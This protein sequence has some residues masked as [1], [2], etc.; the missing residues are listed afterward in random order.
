MFIKGKQRKQEGKGAV[1]SQYYARG[2]RRLEPNPSGRHTVS[3]AHRTVCHIHQQEENPAG[4]KGGR[5]HRSGGLT[6]VS[7]TNVSL[8][9][10]HSHIYV[11]NIISLY[12]Y[13]L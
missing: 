1:C 8:N 3:P 10:L 2:K 7:T 11:L 6:K 9:W 13:V 5:G 12:K 4:R